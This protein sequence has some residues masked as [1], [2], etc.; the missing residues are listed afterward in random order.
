MTYLSEVLADAPLHYWRMADPGGGLCHDIGSSPVHQ[1]VNA[2]ALC[3]GY[4]GPNSDGGSCDLSNDNTFAI[5]GENVHFAGGA[6]TLEMFVWNFSHIATLNQQLFWNCALAQ[7]SLYN[8]N[9]FWRFIYNSVFVPVGGVTAPVTQQWTHLVGTYGGG[10]GQLYVNGAASGGAVAIAAGA[11]DN[12]RIDECHNVAA[13]S[14][15]FVSE[16]AIYLSQL[17]AARAAA[18]YAAADQLAQAPVFTQAG[19]FSSSTGSG[20]TLAADASSILAAVTKTVA[21]SP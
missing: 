6:L 19:H 20:A 13:G 17:S 21:N 4:S 10:N 12:G 3:L 8:D 11:A 9:T 1:H 16:V 15:G 14:R 18:H 2:S 5:T 7:Y